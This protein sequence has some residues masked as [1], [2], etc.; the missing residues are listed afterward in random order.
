MKSNTGSVFDAAR[1]VVPVDWAETEPAPTPAAAGRTAR[2]SHDAPTSPGNESFLDNRVSPFRVPARRVNGRR[3]I[4]LSLGTI[5]AF[6]K[7]AL[8]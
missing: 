7:A 4:A 3:Q 5:P 6:V 2:T 8:L 1:K